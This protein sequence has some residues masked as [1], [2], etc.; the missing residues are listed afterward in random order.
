MK[1]QQN[2]GENM[3]QIKQFLTLAFVLL[4]ACFA[5]AQTPEQTQSL[6]ADALALVGGWKQL[7]L[8]PAALALLQLLI[9]LFNADI[10]IV[11]GWLSK[12][13]PEGKFLAIQF[14]SVLV[15]FVTLKIAG[16]SGI[17]LFLKVAAMPLVT[18]FLHKVYT[19][20]IAKKKA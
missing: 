10:P 9:K 14:L 20:F 11:N 18:E 16:V 1:K 17:E 4:F 7:G 6:L 3:K 5:F 19:L 8:L 2:K 13:A 12:L 15:A